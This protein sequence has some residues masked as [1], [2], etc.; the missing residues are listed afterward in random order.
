MVSL[1]TA[2]YAEACGKK[3]LD[4]IG[5]PFAQRKITGLSILISFTLIFATIC[6]YIT[7]VSSTLATEETCMEET[8]AC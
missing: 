2:L 1:L 8:H 7:L 5:I 6:C 4:D 3:F